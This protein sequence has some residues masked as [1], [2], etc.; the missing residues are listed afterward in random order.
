[1]QEATPLPYPS[2]E[3]MPLAGFCCQNP[4]NKEVT[5]KILQTK[6]IRRALYTQRSAFSLKPSARALY[7]CSVKLSKNYSAG[8]EAGTLR[9]FDDTDPR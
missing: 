8:F 3:I 9:R 6:E 5:G 4:E 1:M 2:N 7:F